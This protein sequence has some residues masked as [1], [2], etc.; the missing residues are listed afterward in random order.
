[1][2][3]PRLA[4]WMY[5]RHVATL[6]KARDRLG[7]TYTAAAQN[8][9]D[10]N[11]ALL[12]V[13][14]PVGPHAFPDARV[15]PFFEGLLPEGE[16]RRMLAHDFRLEANDIFG[17]LA[18][19]GR[20]CA[21]ALV[22]VPEGEAP[23]GRGAPPV[24]LGA[25]EV[26]RRLRQ[27]ATEPLGVDGRVRISLAGVQQKMVLTRLPSGAWALPIDGLPSTHILKRAERRFP[28]M[29]ANEAFCLAFGRHLG[30]AV[31][32]SELVAGAEPTLVVTRYDRAWAA[33]G[34]IQR[35]HQEDLAQATGT[36]PGAK[37]EERGG[38]SL[39]QVAALLRTWTRG[40][41]SLERLLDTT[42]LNVAVGNADAHA[43]NLSL[44]HDE[45]GGVALAPAYDVVAT[46]A[47]PEVDERPGMYVGTKRSIHAITAVDVI[48][49]AT[50]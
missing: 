2:A 27:L 29:V 4:I 35:I 25:D 37:Y 15:R 38:P 50:D 20:D 19:L 23:P 47:Y 17:L 7:L 43:K 10:V 9:Y 14:L 11:V 41:A 46:I 22:I 49:E 26:A 44:L 6:T 36:L 32:A 39:R 1:M 8:A 42:F 34:T 30:L 12:S 40:T 31:A 18:A 13:G 48:A 16:A 5:G 33:D 3:P 28:D 45:A 24:P 21:G